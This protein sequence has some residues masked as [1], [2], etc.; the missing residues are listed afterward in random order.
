MD[1]LELQHQSSCHIIYTLLL[2]VGCSSVISKTIEVDDKKGKVIVVE[3][4]RILRI[5]ILLIRHETVSFLP[6]CVWTYEGCWLLRHRNFWDTTTK[7]LTSKP[8]TWYAVSIA[9]QLI[10]FVT[11]KLE[12]NGCPKLRIKLIRIFSN[13]LSELDR[14]VE[15]LKTQNRYNSV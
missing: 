12:M 15:I 2:H 1:I 7:I 8:P 5:C 4:C 9:L 6:G 11:R 10:D 14:I 13:R 3:N